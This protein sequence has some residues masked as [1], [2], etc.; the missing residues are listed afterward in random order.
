[1]LPQ[2]LEARP[3]KCIYAGTVRIGIARQESRA[4]ITEGSGGAGGYE[5]GP[6]LAPE[7]LTDILVG[8]PC[9]SAWLHGRERDAA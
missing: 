8:R 1:M 9:V 5:A 6:S 7:Q 3:A 2:R 4:G